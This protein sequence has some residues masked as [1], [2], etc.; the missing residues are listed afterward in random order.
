MIYYRVALRTKQSP[1]WQWRSSRLTSPGTL[2]QFLSMYEAVPKD[3]IRI[4][5][6]SSGAILD[7]MLRRANDG[8]LSNSITVEQFLQRNRR[9]CPA[10]IRQLEEEFAPGGDHDIPYVFTFPDSVSQLLAWTRLSSRFRGTAHELSNDVFGCD[11][12][13]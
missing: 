5:F 10:E 7:D 13:S 9:I 2:F 12:S 4:F 11:E 8:L 1:L 3:A 6:A